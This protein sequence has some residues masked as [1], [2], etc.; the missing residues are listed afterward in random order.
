MDKP[1]MIRRGLMTVWQ[2][3]RRRDDSDEENRR[4]RISCERHKQ[5]ILP[6]Y[7]Y[8]DFKTEGSSGTE[9][10]YPGGMSEDRS[11]LL[12]DRSP[13]PCTGW[14]KHSPTTT[15]ATTTTTPTCI[16]AS[17]HTQT[18]RPL[19]WPA[20]PLAPITTSEKGLR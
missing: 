1:E 17:S 16:G 15:A 11:P 3:P 4:R 9:L 5:H 6:N 19:V 8:E 7:V 12:K 10:H 18:C 2:G 14:W 13:S 20:P